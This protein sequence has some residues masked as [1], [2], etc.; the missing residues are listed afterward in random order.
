MSRAGFPQIVVQVGTHTAAGLVEQ[1]P[2]AKSGA[3]RI[4]TSDGTSASV[5]VDLPSGRTLTDTRPYPARRRGSS[6]PDVL[7]DGAARPAESLA[8]LIAEEYGA[9]PT[10]LARL[11]MLH[12][13]TVFI[14]TKGL[15]PWEHLCRVF[16]VDG[17]VAAFDQTKLL[18]PAARKTADSARKV[19]TV[20]EAELVA[21][22]ELEARASELTEAAVV[23]RAEAEQELAEARAAGE[24]RQRYERWKA[25]SER[26]DAAVHGIATEA[27]TLLGREVSVEAL[28]TDL[29]AAEAT[30]VEALD[31]RP[32]R[33]LLA[34]AADSAR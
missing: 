3:S 13:S 33:H 17:L 1:V 9:E 2:P 21:L 6:T 26:Y 19:A 14:E 23:D 8:D 10:I 4:T 28:A 16:G 29:E 11:A 15:D 24:L 31:L 32:V 34:A 18:A 12:S 7:V 25:T 20:P 5:D 30:A 22:L 27:T